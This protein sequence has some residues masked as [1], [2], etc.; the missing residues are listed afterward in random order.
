MEMKF[1]IT[2]SKREELI[3]KYLS[4][5]YGDLI[6]YEPKNRPD[7]IFF[8]RDTKKEP[9][10]RDIVLF[11]NKDD[12]YVFINWNIIRYVDIFTGDEWESEQFV[13]RWLKKT[14]G[15]DP[16]KLYDNF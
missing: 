9:I 4:K 2:E 12:Q 7:L 1:I 10:K 5:E 15:I 14:Y 8:V 16:I 11:Y 3:Y 6:R 13:K